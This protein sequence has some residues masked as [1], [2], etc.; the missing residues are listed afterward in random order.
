MEEE[1]L[2]QQE[3]GF[4]STQDPKIDLQDVRTND[5]EPFSPVKLTTTYH[6]EKCDQFLTR[7]A[8]FRSCIE[9]LTRCLQWQPNRMRKMF[10]PSQ[11]PSWG[12]S[13][14]LPLTMDFPRRCAV[15]SR[16]G[17]VA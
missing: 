12:I 2:Q 4:S 5:K 3:M 17:N 6:S 16:V 15:A 14:C 9:F 13:H 10:C 7:V 1:E 8:A 11:E